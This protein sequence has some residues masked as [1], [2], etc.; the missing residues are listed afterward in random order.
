[1]FACKLYNWINPSK[2]LNL[3]RNALISSISSCV[4]TYLQS[5]EI[6]GYW[7]VSLVSCVWG[8]FS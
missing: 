1:M 4:L 6:G 2:I 7:I 3:T 8:C 5:K